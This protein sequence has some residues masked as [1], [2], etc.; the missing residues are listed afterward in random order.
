MDN[1]SAHKNPD[2]ARYIKRC[3]AEVLYLP[4]YSPD[5]NPIEH[6]WRRSNNC[7]G[8]WKFEH[9]TPWE[10]ASPAHLTWCAQ[11]MPK[12]GLT[13]VNINYFKYKIL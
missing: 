3:G 1:L 4:P 2:V 13:I 6:M 8:E 10:R 11:A 5:L 12:G 9:M 7:C